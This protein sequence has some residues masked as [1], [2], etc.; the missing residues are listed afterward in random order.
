LR[1]RTLFHILWI[2]SSFGERM[3]QMMR[4]PFR[5]KR[6]VQQIDAFAIE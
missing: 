6:L 5:A 1:R 2:L 3:H 4:T